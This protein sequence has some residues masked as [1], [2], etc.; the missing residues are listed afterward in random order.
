MSRRSV[1]GK[2]FQT[3]TFL[4]GSSY[5][6]PP[7]W[8]S[9][10]YWATSSLVFLFCTLYLV[11]TFTSPSFMLVRFM[12]EQ[13]CRAPNF[14]RAFLNLKGVRLFATFGYKLAQW[15]FFFILFQ[16]AQV[17]KRRILSWSGK[18]RRTQSTIK[19]SKWNKCGDDGSSISSQF[20][21]SIDKYQTNLLI[22]S[23]NSWNRWP[24]KYLLRTL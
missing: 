17:L 24:W 11:L 23:T 5:C 3:I 2:P 8:F 1:C 13:F 22:L 7:V 12:Q 14:L 16:L 20:T 6:W 10:T 19:D 21:L 9:D 15:G 4:E 18:S